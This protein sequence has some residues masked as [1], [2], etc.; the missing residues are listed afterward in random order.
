MGRVL[1]GAVVTVA[2]PAGAVGCGGSEPDHAEA[3]TVAGTDL[4]GGDAVS[5]GAAESL[6]AIMGSLRFEGSGEKSTVAN[7]AQELTGEFSSA[8]TGKGDVCRV[9]TPDE[10][11]RITWELSGSGP[12]GD[13]D[14]K[15]TELKTG[16]R[17]LTAVD[18]SCLR[19]G[20]LSGKLTGTEPAHIDIG[21][22]RGGM[23]TEPEGDPEAL[24]DAYATVAHSFALSMAKELGCENDGGLKLQPTL[25]AA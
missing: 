7:A 2:S 17:A 8:A 25:D 23:P 9:Y 16:E 10:E 19:F 13:A 3:A 11:P 15:F 6:K 21:V 18:G 5:A 14:P 20:C 1:V 4:C 22:E 24:K 12:G